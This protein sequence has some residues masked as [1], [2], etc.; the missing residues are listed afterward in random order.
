MLGSLNVHIWQAWCGSTIHD[1]RRNKFFPLYPDVQ[2]TVKTFFIR[3]WEKDYGQR[4]FGYI[5]PPQSGNFDM[6]ISLTLCYFYHLKF[7][8]DVI[9]AKVFH[10]SN[11][12]HSKK[13]ISLW[14]RTIIKKILPVLDSICLFLQTFIQVHN[15]PF[16]FPWPSFFLW[17]KLFCDELRIRHRVTFLRLFRAY[18]WKGLKGSGTPP[19]P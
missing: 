16:L 2:L 5:H 1:L 12:L 11:K 6:S 3:H 18:P 4:I 15:C 14:L 7:H 9:C 13:K 19:P 8:T 10:P 17:C